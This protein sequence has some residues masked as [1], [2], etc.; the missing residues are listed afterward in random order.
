MIKKLLLTGLLATTLVFAQRGGGGGGGG[1][2]MGGEGG[3]GG[4][5]GMSGGG[6]ARPT[7]MDQINDALKLN[8]DQKKLLKT[9]LDDGQKEAAPVRDQLAKGRKAIA[10]AV[11]GGNQDQIN[12]AVNAYAAAKAQMAT[13]ELKAFAK[14]YPALEKD[15]VQRSGVLYNM[16]AGIFSGKN[17]NE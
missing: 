9:T 17:W 11:A 2:G 12:A 5:G 8:K 16:M 13:I 14:I 6:M 15:Q 10:E 3:G 1:G 7:R 4:M